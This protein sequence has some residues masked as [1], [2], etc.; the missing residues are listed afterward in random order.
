[1]VA[2]R[3][4]GGAARG[5]A[6]M[7][8]QGTLCER[9]WGLMRAA[10]PFS[11]PTIRH[12]RGRR[13]MAKEKSKVRLV[14]EGDLQAELHRTFDTAVDLSDATRMAMIE[15]LNQELADTTD[16]YSQTKQAHW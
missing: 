2:I 11:D 16:I 3:V 14:K 4:R 13:D 7:T 10:H 15:L 5:Q 1:M 8:S 6:A 9:D 12:E